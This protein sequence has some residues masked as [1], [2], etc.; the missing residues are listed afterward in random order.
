MG[1]IG[2]IAERPSGAATAFQK[3]IKVDVRGTTIAETVTEGQISPYMNLQDNLRFTTKGVM[4]PCAMTCGCIKLRTAQL[5][6]EISRRDGRHLMAIQMLCEERGLEQNT[7]NINAV[8]S[9]IHR[10][11]LTTL[12]PSE[13]DTMQAKVK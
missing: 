10:R 1:S 7:K 3:C 9:E 6:E 8:L 4:P 5:T 2:Y 12:E 11:W 13:N